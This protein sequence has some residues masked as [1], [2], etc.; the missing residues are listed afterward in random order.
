MKAYRVRGD[1]TVEAGFAWKG[2]D[3][4]AYVA[5]GGTN[6]SYV[7]VSPRLATASEGEGRVFDVDFKLDAIG[8]IEL[9]PPCEVADEDGSREAS[10]LVVI[11][12]GGYD[13][14][15]QP[16]QL[17]VNPR[18]GIACRVVVLKAGEEIRAFPKVRNF[19]EAQA[20]KSVV[21]RY[22]GKEVTFQV[23]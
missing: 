18:C 3:G 5:V 11:P 2:M 23:A 20:A 4:V 17:A 8:G 15:Y 13:F 22:D 21:L 1:G 9:V 14:G 7:S 19:A 12:S 10:A 6:R 16:G